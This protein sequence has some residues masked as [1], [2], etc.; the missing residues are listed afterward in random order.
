MAENRQYDNEYRVQAV[1]LA[2]EGVCN[3]AAKELE[4]PYNMLSGRLRKARKGD[5]DMGE[6]SNS[7]DEAISSAA[8]IQQLRKQVKEQEKEIR[9]FNKLNEFLED[10]SATQKLRLAVSSGQAEI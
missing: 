1:K 8:E 6:G 10:D 2:K 9:R 7:L 5:L 4:S 3:R